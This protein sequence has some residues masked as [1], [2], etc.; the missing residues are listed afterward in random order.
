MITE[1]GNGLS[2]LI[3]TETGQDWQAFGT[4]YSIYKNLPNAKVA[5]SVARNEQTPF[6][7]F[8]W[9]KRINLPV[10]RHN[11]FDTESPIASRLDAIG[12]AI[13]HKMIEAP[14][15]VIKPLVM[16]VDVLDQKLLEQLNSDSNIFDNDVWFLKQ[17]NI[18][19]MLNSF[20]LDEDPIEMQEKSLCEEAKDAQEVRS[21]VSYS[22]GCGKWID[23]LKGCPFSNANGLMTADMTSCENRIVDLWKR[24]CTLY[25]VVV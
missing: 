19:D 20:L 11:V 16:A 2:V 4:W 21:L 10:L 24:M 8:Q 18:P 25:S 17:P 1:T 6:Q 5:I 9:T 3:T 7:Y 22:K 23:T 15:L 13:A 14:I 12:K